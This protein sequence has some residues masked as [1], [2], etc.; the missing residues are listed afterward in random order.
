MGKWMGGVGRSQSEAWAS[1]A[2]A[3]RPNFGIQVF[4]LKAPNGI[5]ILSRFSVG[6]T[7]C[8][9]LDIVGSGTG[10]RQDSHRI[11]TG[12]QYELGRG[13]SEAWASPTIAHR[14]N[15]GSQPFPLKA[16][17]GIPILGRFLVGLTCCRGLDIVGSGAGFRQDSH[18][19]QTGFRQDSNMN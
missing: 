14:S 3:H 17:N 5:P 8:R 10:F 6:L 2:I 7:H 9:G 1:P 13:Q 12:F 16:T 19:I 18:R 4:P 11:P 15:F